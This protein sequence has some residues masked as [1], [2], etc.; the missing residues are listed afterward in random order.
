MALYKCSV[1]D[2]EGKKLKI[3]NHAESR[4][5][6]ID[7][8]KEN[9]YIIIDIKE[10]QSINLSGFNSK[11]IKSKYLA[12]F[13]KQLYAMLKAGVTIVNSLDILKLQTENKKLSKVISQ[14]YVDLQKGNTF[15]K[16]LSHHKDVFPT[17]FISMVEAG[18][19]SGN[20]DLILNRL[21]THFEKEYKIENK[22][23]AAL[24]YPMILV[25]VCIVVVVFLLTTI[26]PTFVSMYSSLGE[27]LPQLTKAMI[28]ISEGLKKYRYIYISIIVFI[29]FVVSALTKNFKVK[30]KIDYFKLRIPV[31][32]NLVL[33]VAT[34][35]F[36]RT[37]STLLGSGIPLLK[38]LETVSGVTG[39]TYIESLILEAK[40][41]VRKG[42]ALYQPLKQ[43][44]VFPPMVYSMIKIG[45]DSGSI[46]EILDKTADFFDEEV[47]A[48]VTR[49]TTMIEP[50][51]IVFM[52]VIIGFV[53]IAMIV[54]MFDMVKTVQ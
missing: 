7:F 20:I 14:L 10:S 17:I 5:E 40:E 33:K 29:V 41:D 50:M 44:G 38:A 19:I 24:T 45:E 48:A 2:Q 27:E 6:V 32:K 22:V 47:D 54:P 51:M 39:N 18:E 15:S 46:D 21:S 25:I 8:L 26:M 36:T 52:A 31:V 53:I 28:A 13:C 16:A 11:K 1:V 43:Q 49:L 12:I 37:L 42:Q 30:L 35:R 4:S 23:K 34:S 9:N 3:T